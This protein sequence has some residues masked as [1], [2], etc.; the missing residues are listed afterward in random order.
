VARHIY[1]NGVDRFRDYVGSSLDLKGALSYAIDTC[2]FR[3]RGD[4]PLFGS[5]VIV[6]DD[7]L[8]R[9]F[10]GWVVNPV[11]DPYDPVSA[12]KIWTVDC[13]DDTWRLNHK[14]LTERIE[15]VNAT[16]AFLDL[17]SRYAP[18]FGTLHVAECDLSIEYLDLIDVAIGD[19]FTA[20]CDQVGW[21]WFPDYFGDLHFFDLNAGESAP[22]VLKPGGKFTDFQ[23]GEDGQGVKNRITVRGGV[24]KGAVTVQADWVG[25]GSTREW[26]TDQTAYQVKTVTVGGVS[27]I[28]GLDGVDDPTLFQYLYNPSSRTLKAQDN[29]ATIG[30]GVHL[31]FTYWPEVPIIVT[32]DDTDSQAAIAAIFGGDGI[33]EDTLTDESLTNLDQATAAG[34]A[35]LREWANPKVTVSFAT[36]TTGWAPGQV[37]TVDLPDRDAEGQFM[38]QEVNISPYTSEDWKFTITAGSTLHGLAAWLAEIRKAQKSVKPDVATVLNKVEAVA[39]SVVLTDTVTVETFTGTPLVDEVGTGQVGLSEVVA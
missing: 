9:L 4:K 27:K 11:L 28:V 6:E 30:A 37:V 3:V 25:D 21:H 18:D 2:R 15:G 8:G 35:Q 24:G 23:I 33:I 1:I 12:T 26:V 14:R 13:D 22:M 38:V 36:Y 17:A 16:D 7:D 19:A 34:E 39:D 29:Q 31:L 32:V 5:R 10:A 20:I